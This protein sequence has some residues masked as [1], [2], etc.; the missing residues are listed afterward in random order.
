MNRNPSMF[1]KCPYVKDKAADLTKTFLPKDELKF[2]MPLIL[3]VTYFHLNK[4]WCE[5]ESH[6]SKTVIFY[7]IQN[8]HLFSLSFPKWC[9]LITKCNCRNLVTNWALSTLTNKM[10]FLNW[11]KIL[12]DRHI[13]RKDTRKKNKQ[14]CLLSKPRSN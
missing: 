9:W 13:I 3:N 2:R 4:I 12:P 11:H 6:C 5:N 8:L 7:R 10:C 1:E 14:I